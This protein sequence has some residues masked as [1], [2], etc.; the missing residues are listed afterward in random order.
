MGGDYRILGVQSLNYGASTGS[1]TFSGGFSNNS[2]ADLLLGYPQSSS[3]VPLNTELD[4]YVR[5]FSGY[6]Q[7]DWRVTGRLTLNYGVRLERETGLAE[8]D[9]QI[10]VDFDKAAVSPLDSLV[11]VLDPVTNARRQILGGLVFAGVN[12]APTTQ[13]NQPALKPAPRAGGVFSITDKT[14]L[15]G[16]WGLYWSPWNYPAA[17]TTGWGQIGYSATTNVPQTSGAPT[18]SIDNPFP[19]GLVKPSGNS[20]GLLT[21]AGGDVYFID[22]NKGAPRVQQYSADLQ[23]ELPGGMSVSVGYTGLTG[24]NMSWGGSSNALIN[25]N[26]IDPKYQALVTD[27]TRSPSVLAPHTP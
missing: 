1:Y 10:S 25:I 19:S 23:R 21:G 20:L 24:S 3:T 9:N 12:G 27:T 4:G 2:L 18:V 6:V 22:P 13:G 14:V 17:G 5:Y 7:D 8:R 11:N 26:Q 15:R 16:G